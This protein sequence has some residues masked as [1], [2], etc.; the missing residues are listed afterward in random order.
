MPARVLACFAF[1]HYRVLRT[2]RARVEERTV[3]LAAIEAVAQADPV[4]ASRRH[5]SHIAANATAGE[6]VRVHFQTPVRR[7]RT[8][9]KVSVVRDGRMLIHHVDPSPRPLG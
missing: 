5:D 9:G 6:S 3:M 1:D 2:Y 7:R 4:R 8:A